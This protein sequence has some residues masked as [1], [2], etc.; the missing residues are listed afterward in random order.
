MISS[1]QIHKGQVK[2]KVDD[3]EEEADVIRQLHDP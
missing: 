1:P 3:E 2:P